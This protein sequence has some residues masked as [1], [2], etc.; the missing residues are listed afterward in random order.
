MQKGVTEEETEL[1]SSITRFQYQEEQLSSGGLLPNLN[2]VYCPGQFHSL[3]YMFL[4]RL[5][6]QSVIASSYCA[7]TLYRSRMS[8]MSF[9]LPPPWMRCL[10]RATSSSSSFIGDPLIS[11]V[12]K[13]KYILVSVHSTE[14]QVDIQQ[15]DESSSQNL[16]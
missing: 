5:C 10:S 15:L 16:R 4:H 2:P 1:S 14:T 7:F 11:D 8:R 6:T 12:L 3:D 9:L 13:E